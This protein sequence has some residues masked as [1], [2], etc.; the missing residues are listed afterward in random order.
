MTLKL[1]LN[2]VDEVLTFTKISLKYEGDVFVKHNSY[3]V[4]GTSILGVLS[5]NLSEP[6]LVEMVE[7]R[8]NEA[9]DFFNELIESGLNITK[10]EE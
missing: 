9:N 1:K 10:T 8:D 6:V 2:T 3:V 5:L 7:K 4:D